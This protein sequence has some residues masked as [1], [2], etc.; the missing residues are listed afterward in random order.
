MEVNC[1]ESSFWVF[2]ESTLKN[3][4]IAPLYFQA[5]QRPWEETRGACFHDYKWSGDILCKNA[6]FVRSL[7]AS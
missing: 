5:F 1:K 3:P 7:G 2:A 4:L 6:D